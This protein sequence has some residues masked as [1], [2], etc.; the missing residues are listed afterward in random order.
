METILITGATDGIGKATALALAQ[1]GHL[2]IVHG[3]TTEKA[4]FVVDVLH[5]AASRRD[6]H[7]PSTGTP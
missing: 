1:Q 7:T 6:D 3:R 5:A 2:V 4:R